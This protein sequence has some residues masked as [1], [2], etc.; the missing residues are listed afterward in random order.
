MPNVTNA[1][2]IHDAIR[3]AVDR[4]NKQQVIRERKS[5]FSLHAPPL[6]WGSAVEIYSQ[7]GVFG[8][9]PDQ[10]V[11]EVRVSFS[12]QS[13]QESTFDVEIEGGDSPVFAIGPGSAVVTITGNVATSLT[14]RARSHNVFGLNIRGHTN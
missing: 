14:L 13:A 1:A 11:T 7:F 12:V 5:L 6:F 8:V 2:N 4:G 3:L 9:N 10:H